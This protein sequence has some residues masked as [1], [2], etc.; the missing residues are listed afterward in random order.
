MAWSGAAW[1]L[2]AS[3][4]PNSERP[5]LV[6]FEWREACDSSL[7]IWRE[8]WRGVSE[9]G[10]T[11]GRGDARESF[12]VDVHNLVAVDWYQQR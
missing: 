1:G 11:R 12:G 5:S 4:E 6:L 3:D 7:K 2:G 10:G 8:L 9:R